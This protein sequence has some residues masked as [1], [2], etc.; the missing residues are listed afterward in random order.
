MNEE[1]KYYYYRSGN[2]FLILKEPLAEDKIPE[3]YE[4]IEESEYVEYQQ[5]QDLD[6]RT[7]INPIIKQIIE[8]EK[9]LAA[10][11]YR[12]IKYAEGWY[13]EEQY[14]PYKAQREALREQIRALEAELNEQQSS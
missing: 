8:L 10:T 12:A 3:G 14:A 2:N 6:M 9:Q 1:Q 4:Q 11:D 5:A 13:T 7:Q